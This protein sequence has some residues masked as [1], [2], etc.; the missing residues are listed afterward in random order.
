MKNKLSAYMTGLICSIVLAFA[1][2]PCAVIA[3]GGKDIPEFSDRDIILF[4]I[5]MSC[6][7]LALVA[8][9][10][11]AIK[12]SHATAS[13]EVLERRKQLNRQKAK[14]NRG[15]FLLVASAAA[16]TIA[17]MFAGTSL[18]GTL[19]PA[20]GRTKSIIPLLAALILVP[21]IPAAAGR[22]AVLFYIKKL[23]SMSI[24]D[25]NTFFVSH[26]NETEKTAAAKLK[27]LLR[28][29][30]ASDIYAVIAGMCGCAAA[31]LSP[32]IIMI[33]PVYYP[34]IALSFILILSA[35]SRIRPIKRDEFS[36]YKFPE[37]TPDE[38]PA[39]NAL[40]VRAAEKIGCRKKIRIFGTLGCNAGICEVRTE[41]SVQL[42]MTLL[43][44]LSEEELYAVLLH[45]FAHVAPGMHLAYKVN[46][47]SSR[48]ESTVGDS[49][50]LSV[51]KQMFLLPDSIYSFEHLLYSYASS[52][53]S[54]FNADRAMLCCGSKERVASALLKLY[55]SD[56][57]EWESDTREGNN[58]YEHEELP[59]D[60]L[61]SMIAETEKHIDELRDA[62][63]EYARAEI[64]ANNATHP[65]LRMRLDALGVTDYCAG[66]SSKSPA[67]DSECQKA[68]L[69]LE[70]KIYDEISPT[71]AETR[72]RFYLDP[73]AKVEAWEAAG[74]PLIAEE[75]GDIVNALLALCRINDLMELCDR[76]IKELPDSAALYAYFIKG[77]QL[78][79]SFDPAG[80]ELMYHAV[81]NNKN[82]IDEGMEMIGTFCCI[83]GRK[84][85]LEHYRSRV[86][87]LAQKQHDEYDRINYIGK[88]DRLSA[89]QLPDGM[90]DGILA[91]IKAADESNIVEKIR[92]V[93][94]TVSDDFFSSMFIIEFI[95]DADEDA[96]GNVMH[97]TFMYLD[98]CS[99]WQFSLLG[100]DDLDINAKKTVNAIPGTVVY[101]R[102]A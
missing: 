12:Y 51:A 68:I 85:E 71:Y 14:E 70:K 96:V 57:D 1:F 27:K 100:Y 66:D 69:L 76:A 28:I 36:D 59:H 72:Q 24:A 11:F 47:Y 88:N 79:H 65:T 74:K 99:D 33:K 30:A 34:V 32:C 89:E 90:L 48:L 91:H 4:V 67:L 61:R 78:L 54:E 58:S 93:R 26:R 19:L 95:P 55:Y 39:L 31:F 9:F 17:L 15:V 37:L 83:T 81:E 5:F 97:K 29:K 52:V 38:Y 50:Y 53:I 84:E 7:V 13:P 82:F 20:G 101:Y 44:L 40:A 80:I 3:T 8:S 87:E 73:L 102:T 60:F 86:V 63:N 22:I 98:T 43:T 77:S 49:I 45:E 10:F 23:N 6:I 75:Y 35:L 42:G 46:R 16:I 92:L 62:W 41:Y 21:V 18:N 2:I 64:L 25:C 56:M 94:K